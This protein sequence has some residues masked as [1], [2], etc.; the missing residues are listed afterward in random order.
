MD[1][2]RCTNSF[3]NRSGARIYTHAYTHIHS[4]GEHVSPFADRRCT[5]GLCGSS[6]CTETGLHLIPASRSND[7][8]QCALPRPSLSILLSLSS[9][10]SYNRPT[11]ISWITRALQAHL[12]RSFV[13]PCARDICF[14]GIRYPDH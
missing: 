14:R 9:F 11:E 8:F 4:Y 13:I 1:L 12:I 2:H 3:G 6:I 7:A 5:T 10:S